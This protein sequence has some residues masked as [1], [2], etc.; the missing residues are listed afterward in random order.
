VYPAERRH[1][2][3]EGHFTLQFFT[4]PAAKPLDVTAGSAFALLATLNT[5]QVMGPDAL[6]S[7]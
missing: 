4:L 3:G 7:P 5:R 6:P 1:Q 2:L